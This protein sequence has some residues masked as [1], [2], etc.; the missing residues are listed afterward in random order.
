L[1]ARKILNGELKQTDWQA[2]IGTL[3]LE[4]ME[5]EGA[6]KG[7][8]SLEELG[9]SKEVKNQYKERAR[10]KWKEASAFRDS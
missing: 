1:K 4:D 3:D 9:G 6:V 8:E 5:L 2:G 7:L 10:R